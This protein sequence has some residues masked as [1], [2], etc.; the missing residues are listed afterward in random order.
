M[1]KLVIKLLNIITF[2]VFPVKP[3]K[4]KLE[5]NPLAVNG[6]TSQIIFHRCH[7]NVGFPPGHLVLDGHVDT[8]ESP[9]FVELTSENSGLTI[10]SKTQN[11]SFGACR[12][13]ESINFKINV[14]KDQ[15]FVIRCKVVNEFSN[16]ASIYSDKDSLHIIPGKLSK[17][18][19]FLYNVMYSCDYNY[20][21][22]QC[23][24]EICWLCFNLFLL[25]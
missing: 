22:T 14:P 4:P 18:L 5:L 19:P 21:I 10:I 7:G 23:P 13:Y 15:N 6:S 12:A 20:D 3:S 2:N 8:V 17:C 11:N 16:N 9:I 25:E 1:I 24:N